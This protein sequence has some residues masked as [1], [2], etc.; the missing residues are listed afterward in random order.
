M[1]APYAGQLAPSADFSERHSN[2]TLSQINRQR[3]ANRP[4]SDDQHFVWIRLP[5]EP[6]PR[7]E[8]QQAQGLEIKVG[9]YH[10]EPQRGT[11]KGLVC[12][13]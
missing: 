1:I 11:D 12:R 5:I 9:E 4:F 3:E 7:R 2:A 8:V 13:L 10:S 6:L